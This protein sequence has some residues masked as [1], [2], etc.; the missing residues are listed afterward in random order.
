MHEITWAYKHIQFPSSCFA[1]ADKICHNESGTDEFV[2]LNQR[3]EEKRNCQV[4]TVDHPSSTNNILR[5][6]VS[7]F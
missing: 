5:I 2:E 4:G 7:K 1:F 3:K 6:K